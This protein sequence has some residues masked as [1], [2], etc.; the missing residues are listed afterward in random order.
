MAWKLPVQFRKSNLKKVSFQLSPDD[1][2]LMSI[3]KKIVKTV[4]SADFWIQSLHLVHFYSYGVYA[5]DAIKMIF[6]KGKTDEKKVAYYCA[7]N[8]CLEKLKEFPNDNLGNYSYE[9]FVDKAHPFNQFQVT[10]YQIDLLFLFNLLRLMEVSIKNNEM[11]VDS[12]SEDEKEKVILKVGSVFF[13]LSIK[14]LKEIVEGLIKIGVS[15]AFLHFDVN[16]KPLLFHPLKSFKDMREA[17]FGLLMGYVFE[18][19]GKDVIE[20]K[21]FLLD[22]EKQKLTK[23]NEVWSFEELASQYNLT[24]K[25]KSLIEKRIKAL[26]IALKTANVKNK[27]LLKKRIRAL[28]I[29]LK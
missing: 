22:A 26:S 25:A 24:F 5:S 20:A 29:N 12:L 13:A 2:G 28:S 10:D 9:E 7:T 23:G 11:G 16:N 15:N 19:K 14:R 6:I 18:G 17:S 8:K 1:K 21:V 3:L 4:K 27:E